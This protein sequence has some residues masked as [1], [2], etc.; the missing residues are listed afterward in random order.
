MAE[1]WGGLHCVTAADILGCCGCGMWSDKL[2]AL[3]LRLLHALCTSQASGR[4]SSLH[5]QA[6][7][8]H[9]ALV[10]GS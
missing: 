4:F 2:L 5:V 7:E 8:C 9:L 1:L 3:G 10:L 6:T